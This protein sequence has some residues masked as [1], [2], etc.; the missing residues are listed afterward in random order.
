MNKAA[1]LNTKL[2][3]SSKNLTTAV[4][5]KCWIKVQY[6][7]PDWKHVPTLLIK[8]TDRKI[9]QQ[10]LTCITTN[11]SLLKTYLTACHLWKLECSVAPDASHFPAMLLHTKKIAW[12]KNGKRQ[13][14]L[15]I[16][17]IVMGGLI[18]CTQKRLQNCPTYTNVK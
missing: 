18:G 15:N 17:R 6:L 12:Q 3:C 2:N 16:P 8:T 4:L 1:T 10:L 7:I 11:L 9:Y 13:V 14:Q 5:L